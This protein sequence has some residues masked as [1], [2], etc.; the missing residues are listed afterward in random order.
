MRV[1]GVAFGPSH[2]YRHHSLFK[3]FHSTTNTQKR[4]PL[5]IAFCGSDYFSTE[6]FKRVLEYQSAHRDEIE[7][8][9]LITRLPKPKGR[10]RAHVE[11]TI[12]QKYTNSL[13][14]NTP[15]ESIQCF[16]PESDQE[17]IDLAHARNYNLVIA[18]SYGRL[19]PAQFL[20][21]L[22]YGGL[23]VHPSLLPRYR[24]AAPLHAALLNNDEY[25]GVSVQTLHPT[26][27]DQ[28][29]V[30]YQTPEVPIADL[31]QRG[32]ESESETATT[33]TTRKT[34]LEL[35]TRKL[36]PM[37]A[38]GLIEVLQERR[39]EDAEKYAIKNQKYK[40]SYTKKVTT[41]S[42]L[43]D[44]DNSTVI[45]VLTKYGVFGSVVV[46]HDFTIKT[47]KTKKTTEQQQPL[48]VRK[49]VQLEGLEDVSASFP[50]EF[51]NISSKME[52]GEYYLDVST[53]DQ[54]R[55]VFKALDGFVSA[56]SIKMETYASC[57]AHQLQ[58][59]LKKRGIVRQHFV[60]SSI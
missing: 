29:Y 50:A 33:A 22:K 15:P 42:R 18:V 38:E 23:N 10:G 41:E 31:G 32:K 49:R 55:L 57:D 24:G 16:T 53:K 14:I 25:T 59:S 2:L 52:L 51:G 20:E 28:G 36:A 39:F 27:F 58:L 43:I 37:G 3:S 48:Q 11:E 45:S 13:S 5:K 54:S 60:T 9:D 7:S 56:T 17:F 44:L 40:K 6:S 1:S 4:E 35:L 26:K 12:I 21:L 19:I 46:L 34:L 47:K 8:V 30:L